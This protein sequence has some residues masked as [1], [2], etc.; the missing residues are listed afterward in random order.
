MHFRR[1]C[2][3]QWNALEAHM[4]ETEHSGQEFIT[5]HQLHEYKVKKLRSPACCKQENTIFHLIFT[6]P[7]GSDIVVSSTEPGVHLLVHPCTCTYERMHSRL[8]VIRGAKDRLINSS[9][10][11]SKVSSSEDFSTSHPLTIT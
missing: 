3:M 1:C 8:S 2:S 11:R 10:D 4:P 7:M 9:R 6:Q 5:S